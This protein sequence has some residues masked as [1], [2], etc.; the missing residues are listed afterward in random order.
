MHTTLGFAGVV[1]TMMGAACASAHPN[2]LAKPTLATASPCA[3]DSNYQRLAFWVGDWEVFDSV[4][5]RYASQRVS[6]V[7]DAC[8]ITAEWTG[9]AGG[10]GISLSAFDVRAGE[11]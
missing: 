3:A 8:A 10:K 4:G 6:A 5:T 7:L 2:D 9:P 11:W 1:A